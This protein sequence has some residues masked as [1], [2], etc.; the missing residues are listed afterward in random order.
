MLLVRELAQIDS[1][2]EVL[3]LFLID[4]GIVV[5]CVVSVGLCHIFGGMRILSFLSILGLGSS[6]SLLWLD[7]IVVQSLIC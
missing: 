3:I 5:T 2:L 1:I 4:L 6:A 7:S